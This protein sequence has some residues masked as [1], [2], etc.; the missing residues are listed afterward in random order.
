VDLSGKVVV[1]PAEWTGAGGLA[2]RL[3]AA[4]ATVVLVGEDGDAA[5]RLAAA[6]E[7]AGAPGRPSVFVADGSEAG[8]D[9]LAA[10]VSELFRAS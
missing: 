7:V 9:A 3:G 10:F 8:L 5:G 4:G 2:A 1:V 6:L